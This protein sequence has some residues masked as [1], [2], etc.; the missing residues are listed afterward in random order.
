MAI[1][2]ISDL[3]IKLFA[4]GLVVHLFADWILQND[5][6]ARNKS[7]LLHPAAYVHAGIHLLGLL[8]IFPWWA[9]LI[10]AGIHLLVDTR[11]PLTWWRRVFRQTIEGPAALHVAMWGDQVV[12]ITVLALVALFVPLSRL[13]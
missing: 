2:L 12:H 9:A 13:T 1:G 4:Y 10:I 3:A 5:W 11:I 6:Q 7:S 8:F